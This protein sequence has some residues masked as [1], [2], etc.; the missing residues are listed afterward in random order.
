MPGP[1]KTDRLG[2][3]GSRGP[4]G[5]P[6]RA[7]DSRL[8][9]GVPGSPTLPCGAWLRAGPAGGLPGSPLPLWVMLG[10]SLGGLRGPGRRV[11]PPRRHSVRWPPP[12]GGPSACS[13][14]A[15]G[16]WGGGGPC[17]WLCCHSD[18]RRLNNPIPQ[19]APPP[20][21]RQLSHEPR[22]SR[23]SMCIFK[24]ENILCAN[25][26]ETGI[27]WSRDPKASPG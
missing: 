10:L 4:H 7:Q 12:G 2:S 3:A 18:R 8:P 23:M 13:R 16:A 27:P 14:A 24:R 5:H 15:R 20:P 6:R 11:R 1:Q 22:W 17:A 9:G 21:R 26:A 25:I 19:E